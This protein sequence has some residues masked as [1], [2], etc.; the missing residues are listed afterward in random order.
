MPKLEEIQKSNMIKKTGNLIFVYFLVFYL[1]TFGD[2]KIDI[3]AKDYNLHDLYNA[4]V[5]Q[6][7]I[8][9]LVIQTDTDT[10]FDPKIDNIEKYLKNNLGISKNISIINSKTKITKIYQYEVRIDEIGEYKFGPIRLDKNIFNSYLSICVKQSQKI[11][12]ENIKDVIFNLTVDK[13]KVYINEQVE[14]T[15]KFIYK[16]N[17]INLLDYE[18][19]LIKDVQINKEKKSF[20]SQE[21]VNGEQYLI[22]ETKF[23]IYPNKIGKILIPSF[24]AFY[25]MPIG[26]KN[27]FSFFGPQFETK[28]IISNSLNLNVLELPNFKDKIQAVGIFKNF[29]AQ[30]SHK[31]AQQGE[32]LILKFEIE[33]KANLEN[34]KFDLQL[35]KNIK[36]YESK[37]YIE[38]I[39]HGFEKKV[40]EF[41]IQ[42][43]DEGNF[44]I[45]EQIFNYFDPESKSFNSL[46]TNV[47]KFQI[48]QAKK[49]DVNHNE[50]IDSDIKDIKKEFLIDEKLNNFEK[51]IFYILMIFPLII[52]LFIFRKF[53]FKFNNCEAKNAFKKLKKAKEQ[54]DLSNVYNIFLQYF[55][56]KYKSSSHEIIT[57]DF[58]KD[59]LCQSKVSYSEIDNWNVFF[60]K[61]NEITFFDNPTLWHE[62][63]L[64]EI[65]DKSFYWLNL[66]KKKL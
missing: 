52:N 63:N 47:I 64:N 61:L 27:I 59:K 46:K 36:L 34:I 20:T 12:S 18:F 5:G 53:I 16:N 56:E 39:D 44:I 48:H 42:C 37:D 13:N 45:P 17:Y 32:G 29:K 60:N 10:D 4:G 7:F 24:K 50:I 51:K 33:G 9:E 30:L 15:L 49:I 23:Y 38:K 65:F 22:N 11:K 6:P 21:K 19:P 41:V 58:I 2:T 57:Q 66:F 14:L 54:N 55:I 28:E 1:N 8:I 25:E 40:T 35:P 26:N 3:K 43:F 31:V 62:H